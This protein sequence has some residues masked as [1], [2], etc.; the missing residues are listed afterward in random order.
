[1]GACFAQ[2]VAIGPSITQTSLWY[3]DLSSLHSHSPCYSLR[4]LIL[5]PTHRTT[6]HQILQNKMEDIPR[7]TRARPAKGRGADFG[8]FSTS[9]P[10]GTVFAIVPRRPH[11]SHRSSINTGIIPNITSPPQTFQ[12]PAPSSPS[13]VESLRQV[14]NINLTVPTPGDALNSRPSLFDRPLKGPLVVSERHQS[15]PRNT[16]P[17]RLGYPSQAAPEEPL[18]LDIHFA[19]YPSPARAV[20]Y[21]NSFLRNLPETIN[22][23][24]LTLCR[25][26]AKILEKPVA[27]P[28][29]T[30]TS[31]LAMALYD[32]HHDW[33]PPSDE[34]PDPTRTNSPVHFVP[35]PLSSR[36]STSPATSSSSL[37]SDTDEEFETQS[38][39]GRNAPCSPDRP[40]RAAL[41][42]PVAQYLQSQVSS[43]SSPNVDGR[44]Q[45]G[46]SSS[47]ARSLSNKRSFESMASGDE[48]N[49]ATEG[50]QAKRQQVW[51]PSVV[52]VP[53]GVSART[54][55]QVRRSPTS[56]TF[57]SSPSTSSSSTPPPHSIACQYNSCTSHITLTQFSIADHLM[58]AHKPDIQDLHTKTVIR[59]GWGDCGKDLAYGS[60]RR[61]VQNVHCKLL[62]RNC[63]KCG[64]VLSRGDAARRHEETCSK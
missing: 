23:A 6:S 24:V 46:G 41:P 10:S 57:P 9:A 45:P 25:P 1:M 18:L 38:N 35:S 29:S 11:V 52:F 39:P 44:S 54:L 47:H 19:G 32:G 2:F 16:P 26:S 31:S 55:P 40:Q 63:G 49:R 61:H 36:G 59:C 22:P 53:E 34:S 8:S 3:P 64:Q 58:K 51:S 15:P 30:Y 60:L 48:D 37:S 56:P 17:E 33:S 43:G 27:Q 20:V 42:G 7:I 12:K 14:K 28:S 62:V 5:A 13:S 4:L 21:G 50:T